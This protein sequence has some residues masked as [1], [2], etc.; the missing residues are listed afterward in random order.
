MTQVHCFSQES[1]IHKKLQLPSFLPVAFL[2]NKGIRFYSVKHKPE[3]NQE[4]G[5]EKGLL[6]EAQV[7]MVQQEVLHGEAGQEESQDM[8][9]APWR[10]GPWEVDDYHSQ[11]LKHHKQWNQQYY[12]W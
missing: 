10:V 2:K 5:A 7:G 8:V 1:E 11:T 12:F 6:D 3:Q 4:V 9:L